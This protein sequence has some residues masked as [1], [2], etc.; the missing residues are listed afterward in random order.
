MTDHDLNIKEISFPLHTRE[1]MA[2][3]IPLPARTRISR[4]P[5]ELWPLPMCLLPWLRT[6][7]IELI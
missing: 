3:A 2:A 5:P 7:P 1:L 4:F 6:D